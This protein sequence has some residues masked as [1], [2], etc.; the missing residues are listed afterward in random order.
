MAHDS[1]DHVMPTHI[2]S[3]MSRLDHG[4]WSMTM[5]MLDHHHV[6]PCTLHICALCVCVCMCVIRAICCNVREREGDT[7]MPL[8]AHTSRHFTYT[9][10]H[11]THTFRHFHTH[12]SFYT[13][14]S[15]HF[16]YT[17]RHFTH[18]SR[19]F[20]RESDTRMPLS[21]YTHF[22]PIC[23]VFVF[24]RIH[25]AGA[26]LGAQ[27]QARRPVTVIERRCNGH[28][29]QWAVNIDKASAHC[30]FCFFGGGNGP[31]GAFFFF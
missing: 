4:T 29:G 15:R 25:R 6:M 3:H 27:E 14:T 31:E 16:T 20:Q 5:T 9:S 19:H 1:Y 11:F 2:D 30:C 22:P 26:G 24:C 12:A 7:L 10:R 23:F 28:G 8:F 18:T 17:S 21:F 13:H